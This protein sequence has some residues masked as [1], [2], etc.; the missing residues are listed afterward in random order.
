MPYGD[1]VRSGAIVT[2]GADLPGVDV[3]EMPPLLQIE[4][5]VI[6]KRPGYPDDRPFVERQRVSVD[7]ALRAYAINGAYQL[8]AEDEICSIEVGKRADLVVLAH[9]LYAIEPERIHTVPVVLTMMNGRV[10]FVAGS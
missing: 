10:T 5:A 4:A 3:E 7:D 6:R 8:R 9:G 1:L 2:Y